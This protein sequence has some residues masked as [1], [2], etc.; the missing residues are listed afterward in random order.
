M[1]NQKFFN[2]WP[3]VSAAQLGINPPRICDPA[4]EKHQLF[5]YTLFLLQK[6]SHVTH[7]LFLW[8]Q[9]HQDNCW[10]NIIQDKMIQKFNCLLIDEQ[11]NFLNTFLPCLVFIFFVDLQK[12]LAKLYFFRKKALWA[13][14]NQIWKLFTGYQLLRNIRFFFFLLIITLYFQT[15]QAWKL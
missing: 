13:Q 6:F 4:S 7:Q 9:L 14:V 15:F 8:Y 2:D 12:V 10:K 3:I 11:R 1:L 5:A